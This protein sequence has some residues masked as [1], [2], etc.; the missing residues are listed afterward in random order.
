MTGSNVDSND[1]VSDGEIQALH[2][3]GRG[4]IRGSVKLSD[5]QVFLLIN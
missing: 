3:V 2:P 1:V 4:W 5:V